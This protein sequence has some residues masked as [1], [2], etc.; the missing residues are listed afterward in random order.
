M[1]AAPGD[2]GNGVPCE[3]LAAPVPIGIAY[4]GSCTAGK[5]EDFDPYQE[6]LHWAAVR[7]LKVPDNTTFYLQFGTVAVCS[8]TARSAAIATHSY[9][10]A[11]KSTPR[12][13]GLRAMRAVCVLAGRGGD[14]QRDQPQFLPSFRHLPGLASKSADRR[15][16]RDRVVRS[17]AASDVWCTVSDPKIGR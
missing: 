13:A 15:G 1:L 5:R 10:S 12:P 14:D 3:E 8:A 11:S 16:Q 9:K 4:G 7:G 17:A 2:P 6:V